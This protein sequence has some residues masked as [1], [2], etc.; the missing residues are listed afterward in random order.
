MT[1]KNSK[2]SKV[3]TKKETKVAT[4]KD[5]KVTEF[6]PL[7]LSP[8]NLNHLDGAVTIAKE[9]VKLE[10]IKDYAIE[11]ANQ[12]VWINA[13]GKF[14][15]KFKS[16]IKT[17]MA[18]DMPSFRVF[19][20]YSGKRNSWY[21]RSKGEVELLND[22]KYWHCMVKDSKLCNVNDSEKSW[23]QAVKKAKGETNHWPHEEAQE[24]KGSSKVASAPVTTAP[25]DLSSAVAMLKA[26]GFKVTQ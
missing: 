15:E 12:W 21:A 26:A 10:I 24:N 5:A 9:L 23:E 13:P 19:F 22:A 6:T 7:G 3:T 2:T 20:A 14:E 8:M 11:G 17:N 25:P 16:W 18:T 4:L 1:Q